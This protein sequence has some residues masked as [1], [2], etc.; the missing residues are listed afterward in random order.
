MYLI[1]LLLDLRVR[2][3]TQ[4][5]A[6]TPQQT[7]AKRQSCATNGGVAAARSALCGSLQPPP[8]HLKPQKY[9]MDSNVPCH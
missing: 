5:S 9:G 3:Q 2:R 7:S 4:Q 6:F 8:P 1:R